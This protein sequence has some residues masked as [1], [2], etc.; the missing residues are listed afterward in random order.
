MLVSGQTLSGNDPAGSAFAL[1][2][3]VIKALTVLPAFPRFDTTDRT[4]LYS[5]DYQIKWQLPLAW[6]VGDATPAQSMARNEWQTN[7]NPLWALELGKKGT[8]EDL[9][10]LAEATDSARSWPGLSARAKASLVLT[11]TS[12]RARILAIAGR[13]SEAL[14]VLRL[15]TQAERAAVDEDPPDLVRDAFDSVVNGGARYF[16]ARHN[17]AEAREWVL[18]TSLAFL[19]ADRRAFEAAAHRRFG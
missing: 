3:P 16:L 2:D 11:L 5:L 13:Q 7:H 19:L 4:P 18:T 1:K 12:Y 17:R 15:P 14:T 8:E 9:P 6:S 10:G